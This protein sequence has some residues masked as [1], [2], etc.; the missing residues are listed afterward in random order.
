MQ[1]DLYPQEG[2][3][4][5]RSSSAETTTEIQEQERNI[6]NIFFSFHFALKNKYVSGSQPQRNDLLWNMPKLRL[7]CERTSMTAIN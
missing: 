3:T 1:L 7:L 5:Q 4:R 2:G 6:K